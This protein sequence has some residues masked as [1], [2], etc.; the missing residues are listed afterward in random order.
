[1]R[2][3]F[4]GAKRIALLNRRRKSVVALARIP[5]IRAL[6]RARRSPATMAPHRYP[7]ISMPEA[8]D[9]VLSRAAPLEEESL[10]FPDAVGRVLA[11]EVTAPR[12]HPPFPASIMDG[13]AVRSADVPGTLRVVGAARAGAPL[14]PSADG[15]ESHTGPGRAVYIT[16]GA[17][18]PPGFDAVVPVERVSFPEGAGSDAVAVADAFVPGTNVRSV[19]SD[20]ERGEVLLHAGDRV[21]PHE[22]GIA[23][24]AGVSEARTRRAPV[25]A[26]L[27]TGDELADPYFTNGQNDAPAT[28][29]NS[30]D[31]LDVSAG[32][33]FDANR[34]MLLACAREAGAR[35]MDL[36]IVRDDPDALAAAVARAMDAGADVVVASGGVSEGDKDHL[37]DVLLGSFGRIA[38]VVHFG[39]VMM[40]PGKPLTFAE[41]HRVKIRS[42]DRSEDRRESTKLDEKKTVLAFGL[43]GNPVSAAVTFALVV[44]PAVRRMLGWVDPRPRRLQAVL[45]QDIA[46]DKERPEYHRATLD[47]EAKDA[48]IANVFHAK[49]NLPLAR[50]TGRQISSRLTS[51]RG[52]EAL[53]ELP[54]GPGF[55]AKG[56]VVSA[57]VIRDIGTQGGLQMPRVRPKVVRPGN[58]PDGV[59]AAA[60]AGVVKKALRDDQD[61]AKTFGPRPRAI[62]VVTHPFVPAKSASELARES[63]VPDSDRAVTDEGNDDDATILEA[64]RR[65]LRRAGVR[66]SDDGDVAWRVFEARAK[67]GTSCR[68]AAAARAAAETASIVLI[69]P[70]GPSAVSSQAAVVAATDLGFPG[71]APRMRAPL[72]KKYDQSDDDDFSD[73]ERSEAED[74]AALA[75]IAYR[76]T[77]FG[78]NAGQVAGAVVASLPCTNCEEAL[79]EGLTKMLHV[80]REKWE[81]LVL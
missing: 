24:L 73:E 35:V 12:P 66:V 8:I 64:T 61:D 9:I 62:A 20:I 70:S 1:M 63:D 30:S 34:H 67:N 31:R 75:A 15:S 54:R 11:S 81:G 59:L 52:A 47:W 41:I 78:I 33:I 65:F 22:L 18:V 7:M 23:A 14:G 68:L 80:P 76:E 3:V 69:A 36:G 19:G 51:M 58:A 5:V 79:V 57:L 48:S 13:Y 45:A 29:F 16:T 2:F 21:G 77:G 28:F 55:V 17:P 6:A 25:V 71:L 38:G 32:S 49:K 40:K 42:E 44:A 37:K 74:A 46:L 43:P 39:R 26:V 4:T 27:S 56:T 72:E 10:P 60:D 53:L 50:S